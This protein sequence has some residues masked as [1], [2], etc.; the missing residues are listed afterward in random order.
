MEDLLERMRSAGVPAALEEPAEALLLLTGGTERMALQALDDT[1]AR[2]LLAHPGHNS[3]AAALEI[4]AAVRQGGGSLRLVVLD[5]EGLAEL[6]RPD[7]ARTALAGARLGRIGSPSDWLV[8]ST[9][10]SEVVR[11]T[12]GVELVDVPL[13]EVG[14]GGLD[15]LRQVIAR[16]RL[17]ALT[18]RCFD[19]VTQHHTTACLPLSTL[20]DEGFVAGC[21]GDVPAAL[22]MMCLRAHTGRIPWMANPQVISPREGRL[23]LAH[24]ACAPSLLQEVHLQTHFE[25]GLGVAVGGT[26]PPGPATVARLGGARLHEL[27]VW[28]AHIL[29]TQRVPDRCRTQ[30][31]LRVEGDLAALLQRPLGNHLVLVHGH[32]A[33]QLTAAHR[34]LTGW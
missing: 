15:T 28:D 33:Q 10:S 30:V 1:G 5:P 22:T 11:Q 24:C 8:S 21:E 13:A 25:S 7:P 23:E 6:A 2:L 31:S 14:D 9:P 26:M 4:T 29:P 32:W 12:W 16:H 17:D 27:Q 20:L 3:L 19:L 18:L 34:A